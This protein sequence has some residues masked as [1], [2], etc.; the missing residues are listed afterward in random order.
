MAVAVATLGALACPSTG[1]ADDP[2]HTYK[3]SA[4]SIDDVPVPL[5]G[6]TAESIPVS[7]AVPFDQCA[8][9]RRFGFASK[10]GPAVVGRWSFNAPP[11][12]RVA[13]MRAYDL[14]GSGDSHRALT[15]TQEGTDE[16]QDILGL[17]WHT[18]GQPSPLN[19]APLGGTI[20]RAYHLEFLCADQCVGSSAL[21]VSRIDTYLF[22][23]TPPFVAF[24]PA[25]RSFRFTDTGGGVERVDLAVDGVEIQIRVGGERCRRPFV[26]VVPCATSGDISME[27]E[28]GMDLSGKSV[29]ATLTDAAGNRTFAGPFVLPTREAP[30]TAASVAGP[31]GVLS[32]DGPSRLRV[33]YGATKITGVVR[34]TEGFPAARGKVDVAARVEGE[35]WRPLGS[36]ESDAQGRFSVTIPK[37]PSREVSLA[38]GGSTQT[39]NVVVAAPVRLS[40]NRKQ[41]KNGQTVTFMGHVPS[42]GRARTRVTLQAWARGKWTPFRTVELRNA[43]FKARYRFSG[44]FS[45]TRYRFRAIIAEDP[46]FVFAAG[47]SSAVTVVV[48]PRGR[49]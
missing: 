9:E 1:S 2:P 14:V 6:W 40:T 44:T 22:D 32:I 3:V 18:A 19:P 49:S 8:A 35:P 26:Y 34:N 25:A 39:V 33:A 48:R 20:A 13:S 36:T 41:V 11:G 5:D 47:K 24:D 10:A 45:T 31:S 4:C 15:L 23:P 7:A 12:T 46:G 30:S 37:G 28:L 16:P 17:P 21:E 43:N 27:G 42:A 29:F 38:Y